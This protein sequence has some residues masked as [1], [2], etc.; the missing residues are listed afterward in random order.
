M[1]GG[2]R[3]RQSIFSADAIW[4]D[5]PPVDCTVN[6]ST[7]REQ[8]LHHLSQLATPVLEALAERR[9]RAT[10]P[11]WA[12]HLE[13][14]QPFAYLEALGRLLAGIAPWLERGEAEDTE[15]SRCSHWR[16]LTI[17]ALDA[18]TD[19]ASPDYMT[20]L[21][22]HGHQPLV[23]AAF[24]AQGLLRAPS[25]WASLEPRVQQQIVRALRE[26]RA[27]QPVFCN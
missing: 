23:D 16:S 20:F 13:K 8:W 5:P 25:V 27:I 3:A 10:I 24:L 22:D 9:L 11:M 19:P 7:Q 14:R 6:E 1:S 15:R 4:Q 12:H 17:A 21:P 26:T 18:A 2:P